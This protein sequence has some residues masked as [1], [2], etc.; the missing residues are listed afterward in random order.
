MES[1]GHRT[2]AGDEEMHH[3]H[4]TGLGGDGLVDGDGLGGRRFGD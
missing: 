1:A 3:C 2:G 4:Q